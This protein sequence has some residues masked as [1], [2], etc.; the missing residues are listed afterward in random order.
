MLSCLYQ[1]C[2][3]T[4]TVRKIN[5]NN[6]GF[7]LWLTVENYVDGTTSLS[8]KAMWGECCVVSSQ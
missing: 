6:H 3:S 8:S 4:S 7:R 2:D 5:L 1:N